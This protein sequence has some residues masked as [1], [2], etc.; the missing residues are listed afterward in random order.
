MKTKLNSKTIIFF[1]VAFLSLSFSAKETKACEIEFEITNNKKEVYN[2]GDVVVIKVKVVLTHRSCPIS[3][4]QTKF[5]MK[6]LKVVATT[7]WKQLST[8][9]WERK[10]K[11]QVTGTKDGKLVLNAIRNCDKDGGFG[12]LKLNSKPKK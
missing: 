1:L 10:L 7:E 11:M 4:K 3:M 8:M 2:I 9:V 6:G 12:S 5:T